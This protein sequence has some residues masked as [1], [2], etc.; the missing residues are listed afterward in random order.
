MSLRIMYLKNII[1]DSYSLNMK[2]IPTY[3][4]LFLYGSVLVLI[5]WYVCM[6]FEWAFM[7]FIDLL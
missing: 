7:Q 3:Y 2:H 1:C 6:L 5:S 4:F